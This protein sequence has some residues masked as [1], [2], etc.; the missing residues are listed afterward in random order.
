LFTLVSAAHDHDTPAVVPARRTRTS[1]GRNCGTAR[2]AAA[3][4]SNANTVCIGAF[5]ML[6][7]GKALTK[8]LRRISV[9]M[10]A[11]FAT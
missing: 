11:T 6:L 5:S 10:I 7:S 8:T 2:N 9:R 4:G 1:W 3:S